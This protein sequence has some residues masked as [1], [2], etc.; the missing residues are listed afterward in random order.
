MNEAK[1]PLSVYMIT[2]NNGYT[3]ERA[4]TSVIGWA[5]E[6]VVVDSHSSDGSTETLA[7]FADKLYQFDTTDQREKYQ[8]AQDKCTNDWVLFI[9]ADEW[10]TPEFK[11]EVAGIIADE[12]SKDGYIAHRRNIYLS[13][14]I[15]HGGWYPDRE[16][17]L[18]KKKKGGWQGGIH[19]KVHI[20]GKT[21]TLKNHYM[22]TPYMDTAHQIRTIE[23]YATAYAEDLL[24]SGKRFHIANMFVRP[25]FRFVRDY[26]FKMGFL[27][28]VPGI[29]I[30]V[31]TVYYVFM[32]Q[33]KLWEMEKKNGSR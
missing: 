7:R 10:L 13:R 22:H 9:D 28:G 4:L 11:S 17:R 14:E 1:I 33:A 25:I 8:F 15:K 21:G 23:R 16:I 5:S 29:I 26:I 18:Y 12:T 31:S 19:A 30:A 27:D 32:K 24:G 2:L 20:N 3:V 6:I